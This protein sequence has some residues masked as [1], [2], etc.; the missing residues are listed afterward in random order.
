MGLFSKIFHLESNSFKLSKIIRK[1]TYKHISF[2]ELLDNEKNKV[3]Q[4]IQNYNLDIKAFDKR[5]FDALEQKFFAIEF[6]L[7]NKNLA[8]NKI[9][10][11]N[12]Y[13]FYE[14]VKHDIYDNNCCFYGYS[15]TTDE[16]SKYKIKKEKLNHSSFIDFKINDYEIDY[17]FL[18]KI[19]IVNDKTLKNKHLKE[20]LEIAL[21]KPTIASFDSIYKEFTS[22]PY[23]IEVCLSMLT[24]Y[25]DI[26]S[27]DSFISLTKLYY[28]HYYEYFKYIRFHYGDNDAIN[29]IEEL[30]YPNVPHRSLTNY[31]KSL[32]HLFKN[33]SDTK[34]NCKF[35]FTYDETLALYVLKIS[36]YYFDNSIE[37]INEYF[38]SV[39]EMLNF[40]NV[41]LPKCNISKTPK[42]ITEVPLKL[43]KNTI[44]P[45]THIE[46]K[47]IKKYYRNNLFYADLSL[48]DSQNRELFKKTFNFDYIFDFI[49][50]LN[51]DLS[52]SDLSN[53]YG[54]QNLTKIPNLNLTNALLND[55]NKSDISLIN[56]LKRD[57]TEPNYV[58]LIKENEI[59]TLNNTSTSIFAEPHID[60]IIAYISDI[61]LSHRLSYEKGNNNLKSISKISK[62][63]KED[64][65]RTSGES[66]MFGVDKF[67]FIAGDI[68][69][70]FSLYNTFIE[71]LNNDFADDFTRNH[72]ANIFIT[73]GNH[74]LWSFAGQSLET[75]T[76]LY[77][78]YLDSYNMYLVQNNIFYL[79]SSGIHEINSEDLINIS[80]EDLINHTRSAYLIIFGGIGFAGNNLTYNANLG[81]YRD[82]IN[83]EQEIDETNKFYSLY[84]KIKRCL[85]GQNVVVLT[86]MPIEDWAN[87]NEDLANF[88]YINGHT[89]KNVLD[90]DKKIYSDNQI[91]YK[92]KK[93]SLKYINFPKSYSWFR[94][95]DDGI[96]EITRLDYILFN[97]GLNIY[98]DFNHDFD[99]LYMIKRNNFYIFFLEYKNKLYVLKGGTKNKIK[100]QDLNYYY[101]HILDYGKTV[102][103]FMHNYNNYLTL[104]SNEVKKIGGNGT[105][106]GAIIDIDYYSH[107]FINPNDKKLT[108]YCA[109]DIIRK[110]VYKNYVSLLKY[111]AP[112]LYNNYIKLINQKSCDTSLILYNSLDLSNKKVY[113]PETDIYRISKFIKNQQ[114]FTSYN[115]IRGWDD[116]ILKKSEEDRE[117]LVMQNISDNL[118]TL[119][120]LASTK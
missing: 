60:L 29:Y 39:E 2:G 19:K 96:F 106:H 85:R 49:Y 20:E 30:E 68:T 37:T 99:K 97:R 6:I 103:N 21:N 46:R 102:N 35:I 50:F 59:N 51:N 24:R 81:L 87:P 119:K 92:N 36:F 41:I 95:Y 117:K 105:I 108:F 15:F 27:K 110:Y 62:S 111:E 82:T 45:A 71:K 53:C 91:G 14:Y 112:N 63:L 64:Y 17:T 34:N 56:S 98:I 78:K 44:L 18:S 48:Y 70:N 76:N 89:H 72:I 67:F 109:S 16:I 83:R 65:I 93:I 58:Q 13:E 120:D 33:F 100:E 12:F 3:L 73:L 22:V 23:P 40:Y 8:T 114:Y 104:I 116:S 115:V 69:D 66:S 77:K 94:N 90:I 52:N 7:E 32:R 113:V 80:D 26:K 4:Y 10:F 84:Q 88:I 5:G 28:N 54:S 107:I 42:K 55:K 79:N 38:F 25:N 1:V 57:S 74:E 11:D 75:I 9:W 61:H 118:I 47:E 43:E 86:H 101:Q 31:K